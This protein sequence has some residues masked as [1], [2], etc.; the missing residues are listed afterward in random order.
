MPENRVGGAD[1]TE[2]AGARTPVEVYL[3]PNYLCVTSPHGGGYVPPALG[4]NRDGVLKSRLDFANRLLR[5]GNFIVSRPAYDDLP[6]MLPEDPEVALE[7]LRP[8]LELSIE[9]A[10][11][12]LKDLR[13]I[14][15]PECKNFS[16][17]PVATALYNLGLW[18]HPDEPDSQEDPALTFL[19]SPDE[20]T[21]KAPIL[22][23]MF[24][25]G[26]QQGD[27]DW[28]RF[29]GF[30]VPITQWLMH[31]W[32][33]P[34]LGLQRALSVIGEDLR[35]PRH[36]V[37]VLANRLGDTHCFNLVHVIK[38]LV[39]RDLAAS[40]L[41]PG[42]EPLWKE[43][44][45]E[46]PK[47]DRDAQDALWLAHFLD[48]CPGGKRDEWKES[49]WRAVFMAP[50][51]YDLVHFACHC[52]KEDNEWLTSLKLKVAGESLALN[53]SFLSTELDRKQ[54][55]EA[56]TAE[57]PGPMVFLNACATGQQNEDDQF[58]GFPE[59][60]IRCQGAKAVIVTLCKVPDAFAYAFA[61]KFYDILFKAVTDR[62]S[63]DPSSIRNRYVAEALL[64][65][66]RFF[67]KE[68]NNPLGLAYDLYAVQNMR[69]E[70][71]FGVL[72]GNP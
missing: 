60:W 16:R 19:V 1:A 14:G 56:W 17:S 29:W 9:E 35:F 22:W 2:E 26:G 70:D 68:Y 44:E 58:P 45:A 13:A 40:M 42:V 62:D 69:M 7:A 3:G 34:P 41:Q 43:C 57:E 72:G 28:H 38:E 15:A 25:E 71:E 23:S 32:R 33:K 27:P 59:E 50:E 10:R 8:V 55:G 36:E 30:R 31:M 39:K 37:A 20:E 4:I 63:L 46:D 5:L 65:T 21:F 67:M 53:T 47:A 18:K 61:V 66:R 6:R 51:T 52:K 11:G 54:R 49:A 24:Y 64:Q 48:S 12:V